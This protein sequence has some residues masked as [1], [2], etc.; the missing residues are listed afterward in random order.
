M[1]FVNDPF[2]RVF[3]AFEELYPGVECVV[4]WTESL[5]D[6]KGEPVYGLTTFPDDG[7]VPWVVI[8][9]DLSVY[10]AIEIL[11]HEL[12]H[13]VAGHDAGHGEAW[14]TAFSAIHEKYLEWMEE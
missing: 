5:T 6:E 4:S 7:G 8:S 12:A 14:E 1:Q 9:A 3:V 10:D 2:A 11:A 13:V